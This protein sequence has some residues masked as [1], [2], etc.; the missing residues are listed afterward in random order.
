M[1]LTRALLVSSFLLFTAALVAVVVALALK[2]LS[3]AIAAL[4]VAGAALAPLFTN[5]KSI[6]KDPPR[7]P[8]RP[9]FAE[10]VARKWEAE[11][12]GRG[13]SDEFR[14]AVDWRIS[15]WSHGSA[16]LAATLG[17]RGEMDDL[18]DGFARHVAG[19]QAARLVIVGPAGAGKT[20]ACMLLIVRCLRAQQADRE[21]A[22]VPV[23]FQ[24]A[25]WDPDVPLD[26]WMAA[27]LREDEPRFAEAA[28]AAGGLAEGILPVF[29]GL[30]ELDDPAKAFKAL[31]KERRNRSFVLTCRTADFEDRE[32][33]RALR[34]ATVVELL[35]VPAGRVGELLRAGQNSDAWRDGTAP[36]VAELD[37]HPDGPLAMALNTPLFVSVLLN[38]TDLDPDTL[39]DGSADEIQRHL[40]A[41]F[42]RSAYTSAGGDRLAVP[43]DKAE[44]YLRFLAGQ[45]ERGTGR[46]A[47]WKLYRAVPRAVFATVSLVNASLGCALVIGAFFA[48]YG[49]FW[50]GFGI[51]V[52]AGV[53][54]AVLVE[55]VPL[56]EPRKARPSI[57]LPSRLNRTD[58]LRVAGNG[59]M[60]AA[61]LAVLVW[62]LYKPPTYLLIGAV[63]SGLTFAAARYVS[64]PNDPLT[65]VTPDALLEADR[66]TV[67]YEACAAAVAGS[68]SGAYLG[69]AFRDGHRPRL[70]HTWLLV[71]LPQP[72]L[73]LLGGVS[74][75]LLS[76]VGLGL[77]AL[78]A[79]SWGRFRTTRYVLAVQ[80][81]APLR[82][83]AFLRDARRR[84]VLRQ[85]NGYYEFRHIRLADYLRELATPATAAAPVAPV[86]PVAPPGPPG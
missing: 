17:P 79:S 51:G 7:A 81:K 45:A 53:T 65:A 68:L 83:M 64:R 46:F 66:A 30:D 77:M 37:A 8:D 85:V 71:H 82:L 61:V 13:L 56:D 1:K 54:G 60:G 73:I 75:A 62:V 38:S 58:L 69:S 59:V 27:E 74:G 10:A 18:A 26:A 67:L 36:L 11:L 57:V 72:V 16:R 3:E 28:A 2:R 78:G 29:D 49:R 70:D 19:G 25:S 84:G 44:R 40:F 48:L 23:L 35:P 14:F 24:L 21:R 12:V 42:L 33:V 55:A 5:L 86:A 43:P 50:L 80:G 47:W 41:L 20:A 9:A 34:E 39:R 15:R 22:P 31:M 63:M 76:G 6:A 4:G 32:V 52:A